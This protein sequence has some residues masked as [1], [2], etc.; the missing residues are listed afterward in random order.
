MF[1]EAVQLD[2]LK[3]RITIYLQL[4]PEVF[5][6]AQ[7]TGCQGWSTSWQVNSGRSFVN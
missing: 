1:G 7:Y 5:R 4:T 6:S 2:K 3:L